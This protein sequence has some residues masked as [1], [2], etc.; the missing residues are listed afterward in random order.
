MS[1]RSPYSR[2]NVARKDDTT[3]LNGATSRPNGSRMRTRLGL[4]AEADRVTRA[5]SSSTRHAAHHRILSG[6][7][8]TS[9][10]GI[11]DGELVRDFRETLRRHGGLLEPPRHEPPPH[12]CGV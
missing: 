5:G 2:A 4:A 8:I 6:D 1:T 3:S 11:R 12:G 9:Q 7:F 10:I